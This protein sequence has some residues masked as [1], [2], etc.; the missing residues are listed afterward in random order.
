MR[1]LV[2][3]GAGFIGSQ[4]VT[5][6]RERG[7]EP[8]VYDVRAD[9]ACDVRNPAAVGRAL[10]GVDA[11]C[12]QA[13]MVGLG[14]GFGDAAEYVSRNDLGTA[15]LLTAMAE[16]GVRRL[17]LAGSMVVYGEGRYTCPRHGVVRP[18]PRAVSDLD[19]GRFEPPCPVC[20]AD[21]SPGLVGEDAPVD[22]R[23][24]YA[25]TKLAQEH[26]AA[27]WAR[28]TDGRAVSLR[29]HNVYGPGMPR[30]TPYAGVASFFRSALARGEAPRV[31]ED[32]RQRRD[33][34][35]VRDVA[36]ANATALEAGSREGALSVF[37]TGSGEPHTVGEMARALAEAYGGP[38]P[39]VTGEYRLGDVRH[40]TADSALLRSELGWKPEV[41]FDEGMREFAR[42]G[43]RGA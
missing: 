11:V 27:A 31:F 9:P 28:A 8:V 24:V 33:F 5:T 35:H 30:D 43:L 36:A 22:P 40:I 18:G 4:V 20:G 1:V 15:V 38:E 6:L 32:G 34:V 37:N 26:L 3:G 17:V 7:H 41:G 10:T 39:V 25:T 19:A 13:A 14:T 29:Y 42:A 21:L 23:N 2:T 16:A 12:H